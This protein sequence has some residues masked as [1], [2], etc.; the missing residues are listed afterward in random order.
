MEIINRAID[1]FF[2]PKP[3]KKKDNKKKSKK[4][5][6][7][8][9]KRQEKMVENAEIAH[10][11]KLRFQVQRTSP[12][13]GGFVGT[14]YG[15]ELENY[16]CMESLLQEKYG[17]GGYT[18][19]VYKDKELDNELSFIIDGEPKRAKASTDEGK[20]K[21]ISL[22]LSK[23]APDWSGVI[24]KLVPV[25]TAAVTAIIQKPKTDLAAILQATAPFVDKFINKPEPTKV[26]EIATMLDVV[27]RL[28]PQSPDVLQVMQQYHMMRQDLK[29]ELKGEMQSQS[30]DLMGSITQLVSN[31]IKKKEGIPIETPK[32]TKPRPGVQTAPPMTDESVNQIASALVGVIQTAENPE[33]AAEG[34][35]G[36]IPFLT[37]EMVPEIKSYI[38]QIK[39]EWA[40]QIGN[41]LMNEVNID[42]SQVGESETSTQAETSTQTGSANK[43]TETEGAQK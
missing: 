25:M 33:K 26:D 4:I 6:E 19:R 13:P 28:M 17:G 18:V 37:P 16:D 9:I 10:P 29:D 2:G 31:L 8:K 35:V 12:T 41:A 21:D 36:T 14:F 15:S 43:E 11:E 27:S 20:E 32:L 23:S 24:E 39:P 30:G 5:I 38:A 7:Q 42:L 3:E 22:D 40:D 1:K 34:I